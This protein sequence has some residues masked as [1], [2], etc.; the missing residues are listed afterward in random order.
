MSDSHTQ[1]VASPVSGDHKPVRSGAQR[2]SGIWIGCLLA[3]VTVLAYWPVRT[4]EFVT[5]DDDLYVTRNPP[6]THGVT[7]EGLRWAF[8]TGHTGNWHPLTWISHMIDCQ[9]Y[10]L[11]PA[12][13]HVTNL[14]F[15]VANTL[16][17]FAVLRL[18][19]GALWRS[20]IV[21]A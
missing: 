19:T 10:G 20:A 11:N 8:T 5:I 9:V 18:M 3:L 17:L 7:L 2:G 15:H 13:H 1:P 21:A 6:V 14:F 12:G 4:C 16:L